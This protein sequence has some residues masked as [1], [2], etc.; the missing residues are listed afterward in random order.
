VKAPAFQ[1]YAGDFLVGTAM[2]TSEEVGGYI[3][4]LCYEWTNGPL[5]NDPAVLS[6]LSGCTSNALASVMHKFSIDDAGKVY[7]ERLEQVR[8]EREDFAASRAENAK[9][10]WEKRKGDAPSNACAEQV[11][12]TSNALQSSVFSLQ[13]SSTSSPSFEI[14]QIAAEAAPSAPSKQAKK[15]TLTD[16]EWLADLKA[17]A[18]YSHVDIGFEHGKFLRWF[19]ERKRQPTRRAFLSWINKKEK[20][21]GVQ[22]HNVPSSILDA[23]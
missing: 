19:T 18:T 1:L 21:M 6:R 4:L 20:P 16:A 9:K 7:N 12:C 22:G 5:A 13:S 23:F 8:K 14:A 3:R 15:P 10:G 11:H 2:M 17:D